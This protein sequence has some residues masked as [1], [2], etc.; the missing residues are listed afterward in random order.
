LP[1]GFPTDGSPGGDSRRSAVRAPRPFG[2]PG[3]QPQSLLVHA[4][5]VLSSDE[6]DEPDPPEPEVRVVAA[7]A[8]HGSARSKMRSRARTV[9]DAGVRLGLSEGSCATFSPERRRVAIC[10]RAR[11]Q[12]PSSGPGWL[13]GERG[14]P[15]AP[16]W[17]R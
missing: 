14:T 11:R 16:K 7:A 4:P 3:H 13:N 1:P 12:C 5:A 8:V 9:D 10:P 17:T 2:A 6:H 15:S